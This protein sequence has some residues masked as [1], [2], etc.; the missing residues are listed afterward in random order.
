MIVNMLHN[1]NHRY[2]CHNNN[3]KYVGS[4]IKCIGFESLHHAINLHIF[5]SY[6][7]FSD[8]DS[9]FSIDVLLV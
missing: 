9:M 7:V 2:S 5:S 1:L 8:Y 3:I 4:T 6:M